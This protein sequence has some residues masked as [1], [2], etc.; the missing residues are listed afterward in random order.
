MIDQYLDIDTGEGEMPAFVTHPEGGGRYPV[1]VFLMDAPGMREE[2]RDM[3]RRL[4][5]TGYYVIAP[6]LYYRE[7]R[8]YNLFETDDRDRMRELM[9]TLTNPMVDRDVGACLRVAEADPAADLTRVGTVGYCM[10]GPFALT[11]A[12]AFPDTVRAAA[13]IHGVKL[14]TE[15]DDSPHRLLPAMKA[16]IYVGCAEQDHWA[17][18][19][20]VA[21]LEAALMASGTRGQVEWYPGTEHGFAFAERPAYDKASSERHWERLHALF[22]RT[23]GPDRGSAG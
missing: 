4:G 7:V 15:D 8:A 21:E 9:A 19:A 5:T 14:V 6:Q 11:A 2:L 23:I 10:S 1:I 12:A 3:C 22:A 13:S 18:P 20:L 16:E 17:P